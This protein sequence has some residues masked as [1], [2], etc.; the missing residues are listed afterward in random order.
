MLPLHL[1]VS[2]IQ[3][4]NFG[5]ATN[6]VRMK[7]AFDIWDKLDEE[8]K[9]VFNRQYIELANEYFASTCRS[10]FKDANLVIDAMLHAI[11][12]PRPKHRYLLASTMDRLFFQLV[13]V[14]PTA[15]T[16][17]IFS[18]S[19]MYGKRKEMLYNR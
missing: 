13:P 2:I 17:S 7:T 4:G 5:R 6:I 18:L 8:K 10:G 16:D 14:L 15:V 3:P 11:M 1:Q 12:S 9:Q 19:A